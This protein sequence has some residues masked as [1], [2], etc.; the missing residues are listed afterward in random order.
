MGPSMD[1]SLRRSQPA[2]AEMWKHAMKRPKLKKTDVE[3]GLGKRKKNLEVD[4]MGDLRGRIHVGKQDLSKLQSRKMKGLKAN[5]DPRAV[6]DD[7][8][9]EE[10]ADEKPQSKRPR[11]S[12]SSS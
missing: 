6:H 9:E 7:S 10:G 4:D 8:D 12:V 5:R 1:L 11:K 2:D 3:K